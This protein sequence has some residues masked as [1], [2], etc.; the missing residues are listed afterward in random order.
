MS[1]AVSFVNGFS[2]QD[3]DTTGP[4]TVTIATG[5]SGDQLL[6]AGTALVTV[7]GLGTATMTLTGT[8]ADINAFIHGNNITWDPNGTPAS[9]FN[10]TFT[11]TIDDN[12]AAPAVVGSV[13]YDGSTQAVSGGGDVIN[14]VG[15]NLSNNA[16]NTGNG[17]DTVTT[18][19]N[20]GPS[21]ATQ[22][23]S[24][25][26]ANQPAGQSDSVTMVFT[27]TQLED[28]LSDASM[29]GSR[30]AL[31]TYL[32]G[33]P[34]G[35]LDL[36]DTPWNATLDGFES[37]QLALAAGTNSI[38][39]Y[40]AIGSNLPDFAAGTVGTAGDNTLVDS[41]DA[42][43]L[44]GGSGGNDILVGLDGA[45]VLSGGSGTDL[46]LGGTEDDTLVG[47]IGNDILSGGSGADTFWLDDIGGNDVL[48]DYSYVEGDVIDLTQ[49]LDANFGSGSTVSDFVRL[50]QTGSNVTVQVD[51]DGAANGTNFVDVA[52]LANYGTVPVQD[53]VRVFFGSDEHILK[54]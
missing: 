28:V 36:G 34:S 44:D 5:V 17:A 32:D 13:T 16:V 49:L 19:W 1:G 12:S 11:I 25:V 35:P 26:G 30:A 48:I 4:V 39:T 43:T 24:Y 46:L 6:A 42:N 21:L 3:A 47:G 7:G 2:F 50:T 9:G 53:L 23:I 54:I 41:F 29:A 27:S 14:L 37:A 45:D 38:V 10:Q 31:Q 22:D 33:S 18:T 52:T 40:T 8:I 15:W 20:N 51:T